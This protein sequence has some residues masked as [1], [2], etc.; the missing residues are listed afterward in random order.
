M[1][2]CSRKSSAVS[3]P[4]GISPRNPTATSTCRRNRL[5]G[6]SGRGMSIQEGAAPNQARADCCHEDQGWLW[7]VWSCAKVG[8]RLA[9]ADA[10]GCGAE[11]SA[12]G[13]WQWNSPQRDLGFFSQYF[14]HARIGLV[15]CKIIDFGSRPPALVLQDLENTLHLRNRRVGMLFPFELNSQPG[16]PTP[17]C[18]Q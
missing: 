6:D 18:A 15:Q 10:A 5:W 2:Q 1:P 3:S 7:R 14:D 9:Q 17:F 12:G 16:I 8:E 13:G 11:I 4:S